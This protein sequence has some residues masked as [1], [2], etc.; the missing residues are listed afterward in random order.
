MERTNVRFDQTDRW[1]AVE[2]DNTFLV[3]NLADASNYLP[4]P[5]HSEGHMKL[6]SDPSNAINGEYVHLA[7]NSVALLLLDKPAS[8]NRNLQS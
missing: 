7:A 8:H 3:A 1:L 2:R 4:L 6:S 5:K